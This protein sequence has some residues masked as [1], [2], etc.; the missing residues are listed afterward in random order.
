ME[1]IIARYVPWDEQCKRREAVQAQHKETRAKNEAI[2]KALHKSLRSHVYYG[3]LS[4][5]QI[6]DFSGLVPIK[7]TEFLRGYKGGLRFSS[8]VAL[9]NVAGYRI[10]LE[11][12]APEAD[13]YCEH[14]RFAPPP[15][16]K[17]AF[18]AK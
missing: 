8:F 16:G 4:R 9:A 14:R 1:E 12:I 17:L 3:G 13:E 10:K 11:K 6:S 5:V 7:I 2:A 18:R 15:V